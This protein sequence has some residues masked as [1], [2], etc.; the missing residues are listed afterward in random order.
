MRK[1]STLMKANSGSHCSGK[2]DCQMDAPRLD[3]WD[4]NISFTWSYYMVAVNMSYQQQVLVACHRRSSRHNSR[5]FSC[6]CPQINPRWMIRCKCAIYQKDRFCLWPLADR[7]ANSQERFI[8]AKSRNQPIHRLT[9][10]THNCSADPTNNWLMKLKTI[11][12]GYTKEPIVINNLH[13]Q[14]ETKNNQA[15]SQIID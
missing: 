12:N 4:I 5:W 7:G 2:K 6:L 13:R 14:A 10:V 1:V 11:E 9:K 3:F 8:W 15:T